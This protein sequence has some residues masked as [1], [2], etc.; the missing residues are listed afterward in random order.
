M[1]IAHQI[2]KKVQNR[3]VDFISDFYA[4]E[5]QI[6]FPDDILDVDGIHIERPNYDQLID[7]LALADEAGVDLYIYL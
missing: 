5:S 1:N 3:M 6:N 4:G 7:A 2:K